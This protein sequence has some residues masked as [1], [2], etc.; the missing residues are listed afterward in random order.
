MQR[1]RRPQGWIVSLSTS[2]YTISPNMAPNKWAAEPSAEWLA[3]HGQ[4]LLLR[5]AEDD[6]GNFAVRSGNKLKEWVQRR[7]DLSIAL[8]LYLEQA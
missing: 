8:T 7:D 5:R 1:R 4:R 6:G 3:A 2:L